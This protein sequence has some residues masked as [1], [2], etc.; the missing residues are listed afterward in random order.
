MLH[1]QSIKQSY[2]N[3]II[4]YDLCNFDQAEKE[5]VQVFKPILSKPCYRILDIS[6]MDYIKKEILISMYH[7]ALIYRIMQD[8]VKSMALFQYCLLFIKVYKME[9]NLPI[10]NEIISTEKRFFQKMKV[11]NTDNKIIKYKNEINE[12][13]NYVKIK[14]NE[15]NGVDIVQRVDKIEKIYQEIISFFMNDKL[16]G[17]IQ[18][19][20]S[21]AFNK[22]GHIP[23]ESDFCIVALG[24][25]ASGT[26][27]PWSDIEFMILLD[28]SRSKEY[29]YKIVEIFQMMVIELGETKLR[30]MGIDSLNNFKTDKDTD[31]WFWDDVIPNGFNLDGVNKSACKTPFGRHGFVGSK[32]FELLSTVDEMIKFQTE[33]VWHEEEPILVQA[34]RTCSLIYGSQDLFDIYKSKLITDDITRKRSIEILKRDLKKF[35]I[36][37]VSKTLDIKFSVYRPID[38]IIQTLSNYYDI[39]PLKGQR[40]ITSWEVLD[41]LRNIDVVSQSTLLKMKQALSIATEFRL[42]ECVGS[43]DVIPEY[44]DMLQKFYHIMSK[45]QDKIINLLQ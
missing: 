20:F 1:I 15:L 13:R 6:D 26:A 33:C 21:D 38:R 35:K 18:R 32:D 2:Q 3:A 23:N 31:D 25:F 7:L 43:L 42:K 30:R 4:N 24:S 27:T 36:D 11:I 10:Q 28:K 45:I 37:Y 29:F 39:I 44:D 41:R 19:L 22:L 34:L 17:F 8:D 12:F 40:S 14:I 16:N 5:F 9:S